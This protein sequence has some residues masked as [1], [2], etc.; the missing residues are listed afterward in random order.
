MMEDKR[1]AGCIGD[2]SDG[3]NIFLLTRMRRVFPPRIIV[4]DVIREC[5]SPSRDLFLHDPRA[6]PSSAKIHSIVRDSLGLSR[7]EEIQRP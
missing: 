3:T 2:A 1:T 7:V 6:F 5:A 4:H